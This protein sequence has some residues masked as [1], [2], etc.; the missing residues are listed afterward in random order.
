MYNFTIHIHTLQLHASLSSSSWYSSLSLSTYSPSN[1]DESSG[2]TNSSIASSSSKEYKGEL[3]KDL[4]LSLATCK[5]TVKMRCSSGCTHSRRYVGI[6]RYFSLIHCKC[7]DGPVGEHQSIHH[8]LLMPVV[9]F[10]SKRSGHIVHN[11]HMHNSHPIHHSQ[12]HPH[13]KGVSMEEH[14][15]GQVG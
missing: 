15:L 10:H 8:D 2:D 14:P 11:H 7:Y 4:L 5:P 1:K 3:Y 6:E 13:F 12:V 9:C